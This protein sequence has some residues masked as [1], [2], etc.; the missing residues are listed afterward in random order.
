M[1]STLAAAALAGET[2]LLPAGS[3]WRYLDTGVEPGPLWAGRVFDDSGWAE[4]PAPLGYGL[5]PLGTTVAY[6]PDPLARYPT[7]WFRTTFEV[8]DPTAFEAFALELRRD[9]GAAVYLNGVEV[10]R[11]NLAPGAPATAWATAA[12]SGTDQDQFLPVV[13]P[14]SRFVAGTNT[15]AVELHNQSATSGDLVLDLS[16]SGWDGPTAITRGPWLQQTGPDGALVRW[17]TDGPGP[18][19]LWWGASPGALTEQLDDPSVGFA[20]ELRISGVPADSDVA[21]AVGH[22][23]VGILAGGDADHTLHTAPPVGS[24]Q[25]FLLWAL[26]DS[27]TAD[28]DAAAV[29]DA[30]RARHPDPLDTD[31]FLML[32][33][34]AYGSGKDSEYQ[35]AVFDFYPE[36]LRQVSLW[37]TLG[38]HDGYSAFSATQTGPYFD[39]FS[40]PTNGEVG[41]VAS[42]TEAYWSFDYA[43]VHFVNLDSYHSDRAA[44]GAMATWL[45]ADLAS[46]A[47]DW[48]VVFFHHPPYS[49]GSHDSDREEELVEMREF[50]LPILEDH[51]VDLVLGGHSHSYERSFLLDGHYGTSDTLQADMLVQPWS[52]DPSVDAAY[53]KWPSGAE[54]HQG[55]VYV[56]AGSSGQV[57]GGPLN[58]PAMAVSLSELGSLGLAFDGLSLRAYFLDDLGA[59]RDVFELHKGV[60]TITDLGGPTF[61]AEGEVLQFHGAATQPSGDP[62]TTLSWDWGDGTA[63]G[64]GPAP[65]HAWANEGAYDVVLTATDDTGGATRASLRVFIDNA[66]PVL[67][68]AGYTGVSLEGEELTF[69]ASAFDPGADVLTYRWEVDGEVL[70][71]ST[72]THRFYEDGSYPARVVVSDDAGR[73]VSADLDVSV[74]NA[75]PQLSSITGTA[76]E[77]SPATLFASVRDPGFDTVQITWRFPDGT[78]DEGSSTSYTFPDSGLWELEL[79]LVDEDGART[80]ATGALAVTN[81]APTV[82]LSAPATGDEGERLAFAVAVADPGASDTVEV[83]WDF[84]DGAGAGDAVEH[85]FTDDGLQVVTVTATDSDGAVG[86]ATAT[87]EVANLP[88]RIATVQAPGAVDEG[89]AVTLRLAGSDPGAADTLRARWSL[90]SAGQVTGDEVVVSWPGDGTVEAQVTLTDDDGGS[91]SWPFVVEVANAAPTF[92]SAPPVT[93]VDPGSRFTYAP[94]IADPDAVTLSL[95]EG[96]PGARVAGGELSWDVPDAPGTTASFRLRADDGDGGVAEQVF[97]LAVAGVS[98]AP[99]QRLEPGQAPARGCST[100]PGLPT[101]TGLLV[102]LALIRRPQG[103]TRPG[104][105]TGRGARAA[106]TAG[107]ARPSR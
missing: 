93:R 46:T 101:S 22:P 70:Y 81:A 32:G 16:I 63:P 69:S 80:V 1:I 25:P 95:A 86:T 37:A 39:V 79:E 8:P 90:G 107:R 27:G 92:V 35:E 77:G 9:D 78:T 49:K 64:D 36:W 10:A 5:V 98:A 29:R 104:R 73:S 60:T 26:G 52:G 2:P 43:N 15:V 105:P 83:S 11:S 44:D 51:G 53:T 59:E 47:Q 68:S 66:A 34:N 85:A 87:V 3:T 24:R 20:H 88:P 31:V 7:T 6:G 106:G 50:L 55:A 100:G 71:G 91:T 72:V 102:A 45:R 103:P 82:T 23:S 96:P 33:D 75:A 74:A 62:V 56:V 28:P 38:N 13:V 19:R 61:G 67:V 17:V 65:T 89:T 40:F 84:G 14:A 99:P 58:H 30:W 94:V 4:G 97:A 41:G 21:Y 48:T 57:S 54:P 18:G 76:V 42:G 12:V